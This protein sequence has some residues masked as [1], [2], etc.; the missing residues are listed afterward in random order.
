VSSCLL[1]QRVHEISRNTRRIGQTICR[2][3]AIPPHVYANAIRRSSLPRSFDQR[4]GQ[5]PER[6]A[7]RRRGRGNNRLRRNA[8]D[9]GARARI[10]GDIRTKSVKVGGTVKGNIFVTER[11]E[12]QTGCTLRGDIKAP[13]LVINENATF[14]GSA[15][16]GTGKSLPANRSQQSVKQPGR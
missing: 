14:L 11:C 12:L 9:R 2:P 4:L 16:V 5:I 8:H 13:Q 10:R 3:R 6:A 15:K 1:R 7:H